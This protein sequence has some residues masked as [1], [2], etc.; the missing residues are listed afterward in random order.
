MNEKEAGSLADPE[1]GPIPSAH[2][3]IISRGGTRVTYSA[4]RVRSLKPSPKEVLV[5]AIGSHYVR[6][7][8]ANASIPRKIRNIAAFQ[9]TANVV[10]SGRSR[11]QKSNVDVS[12]TLE[13]RAVAFSMAVDEIAADMR[14]S[15]RRRGGGKPIPWK[16][17][18]ETVDVDDA[19]EGEASSD[20]ICSLKSGKGLLV[21][22]AAERISY[23]E[24]QR[25]NFEIISPVVDGRMAWELPCS[26]SL[27]R[28]ALDAVL[29]SIARQFCGTMEL[30]AH[31]STEC[32]PEKVASPAELP[33]KSNV[34]EAN[35]HI[36]L[37]V[38]EA[39]D[40]SDIAEFV[41][42]LFR[43]EEL[44]A[45]A[46]FVHHSSASCALSAGLSTCV[47]LDIGYSATTIAC[48]EEGCVLGDSRVHLKYGSRNI[49]AVFDRLL[50]ESGTF[51]EVCGAPARGR[52]MECDIPVT[53]PSGD[54]DVSMQQSVLSLADVA[55]LT[56]KSCE[57]LCGFNV[58]ENDTLSVAMIRAPK[59]GKMFRIKCGVGVRAVPAYGMLYPGLYESISN[60]HGFP[61]TRLSIPGVA[62][63][64]DEDNFMMGLFDDI[65]RSTIVSAAV[66]FG[67]FANELDAD[68]HVVDESV[69]PWRASVVEALMWSVNRAVETSAIAQTDN[70]RGPELKRRYFKSILLAGGGSSV[71][72][73]ALAL[74]SRLKVLLE[75][76]N[77]VVND[78]T[79]IDGAKGKGDEELLA[80]AG[81]L[82]S[83]GISGLDDDGDP[84]SLPWKGGAVMVEADAVK[85]LWVY[86]DEWMSRDVRALRERAPFYW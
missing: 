53:S 63:N 19:P 74:E 37:I 23:D 22:T 3:T 14:L 49:V 57:Q 60:L 29:T 83:D 7:G 31:S 73:I 36:A 65:K 58:D 80:A 71:D 41:S 21:G 69:H 68:G 79:V 40:R 5:I 76:N 38:P 8:S 44:R 17:E 66:P 15:D 50:R 1:S 52:D 62:R 47:V 2:D 20:T 86:R 39:S 4:E 70:V 9:K 56:R 85:D 11:D 27:V 84:A 6:Y 43:V 72:G 33:A 55:A 75:E 81:M 34:S 18:I 16:V 48:V 45:G 28:S 13:E 35:T 30:V 10:G 64:S 26:K 59:S 67:R 42:A 46:V 82:R 24:D 61:L 78:V 54:N 77:I 12:D 32:A 51:D 25:K